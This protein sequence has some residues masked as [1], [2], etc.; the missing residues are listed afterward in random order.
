[1]RLERWG[2]AMLLAACACGEKPD[3]PPADKPGTTRSAGPA[4][5]SMTDTGKRKPADF[6]AEMT[7]KPKD[8]AAGEG[9]PESFK[10]I[11]KKTLP[12]K[13]TPKKVKPEKEQKGSP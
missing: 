3:A 12:A 8:F 11:V 2:L 9:V 7:E 1:M 10:A 4:A 6:P 5:D 13:S